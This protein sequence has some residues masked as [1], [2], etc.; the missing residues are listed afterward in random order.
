MSISD[1]FD[2]MYEGLSMIYHSKLFGTISIIIIGFSLLTLP[3]NA[4]NRALRNSCRELY[5]TENEKSW[6]N[7]RGDI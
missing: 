2:S 1:M 5:K 6:N 4:M 7:E 3:V